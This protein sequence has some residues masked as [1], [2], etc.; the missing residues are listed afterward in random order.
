MTEIE[1]EQLT[2]SETTLKR[3][4]ELEASLDALSTKFSNDSDQFNFTD[5]DG[6]ENKGN[7]SEYMNNLKSIS[8]NVV[9]EIQSKNTELM[10]KDDNDEDIHITQVI[11]N[12]HSHIE[13]KE[14]E[15]TNK[16]DEL[17]KEVDGYI[18]YK[19]SGGKTL[20]SYTSDED[21]IPGGCSI[22]NNKKGLLYNY[23]FTLENNK[24]L[25]DTLFRKIESLLPGATACGLASSFYKSK[26]E[27]STLFLNE[28]EP[29]NNADIT[30][31]LVQGLWH[32][33]K[34]ALTYC[35]FLAPLGILAWLNY[36]YM[37]SNQHIEIK[38]LFIR[39]ILN[40]PLIVISFFGWYTIHSRKKI[41]EEYNQ[42]QRILELYIGL[43]KSLKDN[44]MEDA[45][46][47]LANA[48]IEITKREPSIIKENY[49]ENLKDKILSIMDDNKNV[50]NSD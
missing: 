35:I 36:G 24:L 39:I 1:K 49:T 47:E 38:Q 11:K 20:I 46:K 9:Q 3:C 37:T 15:I 32:Y 28:M 43:S 33:A 10:L 6:K 30:K 31:I 21:K 48:V 17:K 41:Y 5:V 25:F 50:T 4:K 45:S 26:K 19:D 23:N 8:D 12:A 44:D 34:I 18:E 7:Y 14:T 42:K 22:I 29:K 27:Y 13:K 16:L 2:E 40:S